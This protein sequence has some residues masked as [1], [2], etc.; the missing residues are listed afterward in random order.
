[1]TFTT[2]VMV[3]ALSLGAAGKAPTK[4]EQQKAAAAK[5]DA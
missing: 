1:M 2:V 5:G 4:A 3:A